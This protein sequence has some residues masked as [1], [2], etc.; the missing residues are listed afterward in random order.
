MNCYQMLDQRSWIVCLLYTVF[1]FYFKLFRV[2]LKFKTQI[3]FCLFCFFTKNCRKTQIFHV[4]YE[5]IFISI[6]ISLVWSKSSQFL[7]IILTGFFLTIA[8]RGVKNIY[9]LSVPNRLTNLSPVVLTDFSEGLNEQTRE[10]IHCVVF[11][12]S[13][14]QDGGNFRHLGWREPSSSAQ[15]SAL[16][17]GNPQ[18]AQRALQAHGRTL[19]LAF[20]FI[21]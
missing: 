4:S 8:H 21:Q 3:V 10:M 9:H 11:R 20:L 5:F 19:V 18:Q 16:C 12:S 13:G 14:G 7:L 6:C 1:L 17:T 15:W 2:N